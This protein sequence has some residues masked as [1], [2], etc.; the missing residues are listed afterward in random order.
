[1]R[2]A[3][4]CNAVL[5]K[6]VVCLGLQTPRQSK[7]GGDGF[8]TILGGLIHDSKYRYLEE[9]VFQVFKVLADVCMVALGLALKRKREDDGADEGDCEDYGSTSQTCIGQVFRPH[10]RPHIQVDLNQLLLDRITYCFE[11]EN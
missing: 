9:W 2:N 7:M 11:S 1:M 10:K 5:G 6:Y 4:T 3:L 8:E